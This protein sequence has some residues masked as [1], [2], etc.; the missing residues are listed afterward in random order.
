MHQTSFLDGSDLTVAKALA[1]STDRQTSHDAARQLVESGAHDSQKQA[2]YEALQKHGPCTARELAQRSGVEQYAIG[3]R[4]SDLARDGR[5][6]E[7]GVKV[8]NNGRSATVWR[9]K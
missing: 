6:E 1:R 2:V 8:Q 7:L 5:I 4:I 3:K 9:V